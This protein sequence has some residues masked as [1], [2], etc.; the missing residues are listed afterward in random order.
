M[1]SE[2]QADLSS[3]Y[4]AAKGAMEAVADATLS[5]GFD[6]EW[7]GLAFEQRQAG[8][9]SYILF[10]L[11]VLLVYFT[12]AALYESWILPFAVILIVPMC[13]LSAM[14][15]VSYRGF[16]NNILTQIDLVVLLGLA[17]KNA[18]LIVEFARQAE[19]NGSTRIEAAVEAA[20]LRLRPIL[21]NSP[22]FILGVIPLVFATGPGAELRQAIATAVFGS[23]IGVTFFGLLFTPVFYVA[24]RWLVSGHKVVA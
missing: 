15:G 2:V 10:A 16:D 8:V 3:T 24:C 6:M 11:A 19:T 22:A 12:L 18:I 5:D 13:L 17:A 9:T 14:A 4:K 21:M 7:T 1:G 20:R 23:M